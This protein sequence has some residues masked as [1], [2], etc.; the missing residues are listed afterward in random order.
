MGTSTRYTLL[1]ALAAVLMAAFLLLCTDSS[2]RER[3]RSKE[4]L[5]QK[6]DTT[7]VASVVYTDEFLDTV[8][9]TKKILINDYTTIGVQ[10]GVGMNAMSFNPP[11]KQGS[12]IT[13][14]NFGV[15]V[16]NY[17]KMFGFLPYFG[18][19]AGFFYGQDGYLFKQNKEGDYP[20][21][22]DGA[23]KCIY[24]VVE[25]DLL[26]L[27]HADVWRIRLMANLGI[28][29]GYRMKIQRW[30]DE[31][32]QQY[33]TSFHDYERR[34]DYGAKFG[35]GIGVI[36][37]PIEVVFKADYKWGWS[38][39]YR[40]DYVSEYYYRFAYPSDFLFSVGVHFQLSK[41][42]GKTKPQLR[43]EARQIVYNPEPSQQ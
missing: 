1:K 35:A 14:V 42:T 24:D 3:K 33:A 17:G 34:M 18:L 19:Q 6:P 32:D 11:K 15:T 36:F 22:V 20:Y 31:M 40:P 27:F 38:S 10:Y 5:P 30:G 23:I 13:P 43:R 7:K 25:G 16:T 9:I 8:K 26:T 39:L 28:Y 12:L 2:A 41:R 37:D 21:D 4:T 29:G